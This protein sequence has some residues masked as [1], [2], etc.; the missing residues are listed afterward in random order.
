MRDA[1]AI[2][3]A[4]HRCFVGKLVEMRFLGKRVA[5]SHFV[6]LFFI[7][8]IILALLSRSLPVV[9]QIR[10]DI[11][12]PP[13]PSPLRYVPSFLSREELSIFFPR[14]L[15]SNSTM[16]FFDLQQHTSKYTISAHRSQTGGIPKLQHH[17]V[18]VRKIPAAT[19]A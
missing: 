2:L 8:S 9:T 18:V 17:C 4:P 16:L 13:P 3:N 10:G 5:T 19:V 15:A 14:R 6:C 7:T 11:A 1:A 12:G